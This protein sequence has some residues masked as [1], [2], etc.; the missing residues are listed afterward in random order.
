M[1]SSD[2]SMAAGWSRPDPRRA[3]LVGSCKEIDKRNQANLRK[4]QGR[5]AVNSTTPVEKIFGDFCA[6]GMDQAAI[7]A[8]RITVIKAA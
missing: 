2:A 8:A 5:V 1:I 6:S 4:I 7:E 3:N